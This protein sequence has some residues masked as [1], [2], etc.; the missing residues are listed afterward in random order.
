MLIVT[1]FEVISSDAGG[2]PDEAEGSEE[3]GEEDADGEAF[4]PF[5]P[6][7]HADKTS[8]NTIKADSNVEIL[9]IGISPF[10]L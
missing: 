7:L 10:Q 3:E 1:F 8:A 9:R 5:E 6:P 2:S 4:P